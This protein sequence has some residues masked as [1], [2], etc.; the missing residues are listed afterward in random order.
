LSYVEVDRRGEVWVIRLNRPD[1]MNALGRQLM[2]EFAKAFSEFE[3]EP[4]ARVAVLTGTGRAF[5]AGMDFKEWMESGQDG[6][7]LPDIQP[8]V[9][10]FWDVAGGTMW[11]R[12]E[13][14]VIA[15]VN[16]LAL[17]GGYYLATFA[18]LCVSA[19]SAQFEVTEVRRGFST[20]WEE[21][22]KL[23]LP[24]AVAM[25]L[26]LGMRITARRAYEAGL[27]NRVVTDGEEV[28]AAIEIAE[29]LL[30]VPPTTLQNS[31][32]L[33][34]ADTPGP[35]EQATAMLADV[36]AVEANSPDAV[37]AAQAIAERRRPIYTS[38]LGVNDQYGGVRT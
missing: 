36:Q 2:M 29:H 31:R 5:C 7:G 3:D 21:G 11:R 17:G 20:G 34:W 23:N 38:A 37:E 18:D 35:Q 19:E 26:A 30:D 16:G 15:A 25:E 28:T 12:L 13:K 27:V 24:R 1:R 32:R 33:L 8:L 14:V 9:N 22:R 6:I 10:P 4:A